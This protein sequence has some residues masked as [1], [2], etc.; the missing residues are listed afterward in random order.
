MRECERRKNEKGTVVQM[1]IF[2]AN[3]YFNV[4]MGEGRP[5]QHIRGI[6]CDVKN[7]VYHDGDNFCT[8]DRIRVGPG[9]ARNSAET[10]CATFKEKYR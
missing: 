10:A 9:H 5:P 6:I 7:C 2:G 3:E 4:S 1:E 8:A